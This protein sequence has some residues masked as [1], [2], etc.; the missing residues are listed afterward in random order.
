LAMFA[1]YGKRVFDRK[2]QE[3]LSNPSNARKQPDTLAALDEQE[4]ESTRSK[5]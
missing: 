3:W 5:F 2:D 1:A 4:S